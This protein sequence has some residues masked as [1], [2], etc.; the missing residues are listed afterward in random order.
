MSIDV[1]AE[2]AAVREAAQVGVEHAEPVG[3]GGRRDAAGARPVDAR[4]D[5]RVQPQQVGFVEPV[6]FSPG[7]PVS[8]ISDEVGPAGLVDRLERT[9]G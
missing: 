5:R 8:R 6:K 7:T 1:V 9:A 2:P 4:R 3:R